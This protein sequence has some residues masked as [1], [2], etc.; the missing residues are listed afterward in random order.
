MIETIGVFPLFL[1]TGAAVLAVALIVIALRLHR[2]PQIRYLGRIE[3]S[4]RLRPKH[5]V[6]LRRLARAAELP[7]VSP[8]LLAPSVFDNAVDR[9]GPGIDELAQI[10]ELR[11]RISEALS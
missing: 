4:F 2:S 1:G 11:N 8:L 9:L 3:S 5:R 7:D 6:L 10:E